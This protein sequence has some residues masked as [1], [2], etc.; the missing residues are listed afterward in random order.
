[1]DSTRPFSEKYTKALEWNLIIVNHLWLEE[2]YINHKLQQPSRICYQYYPSCLP[3]IVGDVPI[4]KEEVERSV[5]AAS[6]YIIPKARVL[7]TR[8]Y[9]TKKMSPKRNNETALTKAKTAIP[10]EPPKNPLAATTARTTFSSNTEKIPPP[11]KRRIAKPLQRSASTNVTMPDSAPPKFK[12]LV[13]VDEE[14]MQP[15][16]RRKKS[17][18]T[19]HDILIVLDDDSDAEKKAASASTAPLDKKRKLSTTVTPRTSPRNSRKKAKLTNVRISTT[20]VKLEHRL[21]DV[22]ALG[23]EEAKDV[24][25][26]THLIANKVART[27]KFLLGILHAKE[28]VTMDWVSDS[29]REGTWK[30]PERYRLKDREAEDRLVFSLEESL[31]GAQTQGVF[32]GYTVYITPNITPDEATLRRLIEA[33]GGKVMQKIQLREL[34]KMESNS[35]VGQADHNPAPTSTP[36]G[37]RVFCITSE[38]DSPY[39]AALRTQGLKLYSS[40]LIL[41][42]CLRQELDFDDRSL[43]I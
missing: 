25:T 1:M 38:H 29:I 27:E 13:V 7:P 22:I 24:A 16:N 3:L 8:T 28:I 43:W 37:S 33:G 2:T 9:Q 36:N 4:P 11:S 23:G 12:E 6:D 20:G 42:G 14:Q 21:K 17:A 5:A 39:H 35:L 26:C 15:P 10:E 32:Q 40:E 19:D 41:M 18:I 30:E 34:R 31:R